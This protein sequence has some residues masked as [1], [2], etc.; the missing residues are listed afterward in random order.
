MASELF[1]DPDYL[2]Q[3]DNEL[4]FNNAL[5]DLS[6]YARRKRSIVRGTIYK[7][8]FGVEG[9]SDADVALG[10]SRKRD[11]D[12]RFVL[13]LKKLVD[14][15]YNTNLPDRLRRYTFTPITMPTRTALQDEPGAARTFLKSTRS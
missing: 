14:L 1:S 15:I 4:A 13:E 10:R 6:D 7:D 12:H 9:A 8:H 3:E 5:D 2:H 11:K